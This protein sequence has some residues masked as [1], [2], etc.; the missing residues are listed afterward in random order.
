M[1]KN[2]ID[3]IIKKVEQLN[4]RNLKADNYNYDE[5]NMYD[6]EKISDQKEDSIG[7]TILDSHKIKINNLEVEIYFIKLDS[8]PII[9]FDEKYNMI[10]KSTI[11]QYEVG[12]IINYQDANDKIININGLSRLLSPNKEVVNAKYQELKEL[13]NN[14]DL[15][16]ILKKINDDLD[17]EINS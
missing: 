2:D 10:P 6:S 1:Y 3:C 14:N 17:I 12:I 16:E 11:I 13:L 8:V 4:S 15:D 5:Y 7:N 9:T